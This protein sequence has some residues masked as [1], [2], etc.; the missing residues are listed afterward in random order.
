MIAVVTRA[1]AARAA[2]V[3][4]FSFAMLPLVSCGAVEVPET[5]FY[6]LEP[7]PIPGPISVARRVLRVEAFAVAPHLAGDRLITAIGPYRLAP[8]AHDLWAAPLDQL[9][10]DASVRS[11]LESRRF[12]AVL[13]PTERGE[14][15]LSVSARVV[16][17]EEY[18]DGGAWAG[19]AE[20]AF[21]LRDEHSGKVVWQGSL[22]EVVPTATAEPTH[23]VHA[24]NLALA[25]VLTR[26][27]SMADKEGSIR[28]TPAR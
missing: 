11:L 27:C 21:L 6:R 7:A 12:K 4:W 3:L 9:V 1:A 5:R 19:R 15:D 2:Q 16:Q 23:V 14:A 24:L 18:G 20:V 22:R 8:H 10:T 17:F 26:F 25:K 13:G 28:A